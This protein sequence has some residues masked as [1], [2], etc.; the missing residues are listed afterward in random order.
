MTGPAPTVER[1][2][3]ATL[4]RAVSRWHGNGWQ[5]TL[6][7]L[8]CRAHDRPVSQPS[9]RDALSG[10]LPA[11]DRISAR[12]ICI[13]PKWGSSPLHHGGGSPRNSEQFSSA[14]ATC[15]RVDGRLMVR[16]THWEGRPMSGM[17]RREFV[18]LLFGGAALPRAARAQQAAMPV[19]GFVSGG[20]P[21]TFGYLVSAFR[22]GLSDTGYRNPSPGPSASHRTV[23]WPLPSR[24]RHRALEKGPPPSPPR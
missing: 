4:A 7:R 20:S 6:D 11:C 10:F 24:A 12:A 3:A 15:H 8:R 1:H 9:R 2:S 23:L 17:G 13:F 18:T 5:Q 14:T 16:Q 22:Q 21:D 19:I